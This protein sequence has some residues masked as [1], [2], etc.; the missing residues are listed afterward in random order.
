M[1]DAGRPFSWPESGADSLSTGDRIREMREA[2]GWTLSELAR[3]I[4]STPTQVRKLETGDLQV[5][6]LWMRRFARAFGVKMA[7]LL[8][9]DEID[10]SATGE[11]AELLDAFFAVPPRDRPILLAAAREV[12]GVVRRMGAKAGA[13]PGDP[14]LSAEMLDVWQKWDDQ[15][16]RAALDLLRAAG[17]MET[18]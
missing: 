13:L 4:D 7:A 1:E 8:P 12:V 14:A 15:Q 16:R 11:A 18:R 2:R 6:L 3:R 17:R 9:P 10:I 5:S